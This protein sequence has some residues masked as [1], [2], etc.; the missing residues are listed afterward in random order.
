MLIALQLQLF[1]MHLGQFC[2]VYSTLCNARMMKL[3][4]QSV[5]R[6]HFLVSLLISSRSTVLN[7]W[8]PRV[9]GF[10]NCCNV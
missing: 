9:K 10:Q 7:Y 3:K 6:S 5:L 8:H 4:S 2:L 1:Y